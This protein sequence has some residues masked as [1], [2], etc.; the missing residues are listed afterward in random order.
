[1]LVGALRSDN[2]LGGAPLTCDDVT[3]SFTLQGVGDT[4][5]PVFFQP[6]V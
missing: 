1:M 5:A 3:E 2:P 4:T 6:P